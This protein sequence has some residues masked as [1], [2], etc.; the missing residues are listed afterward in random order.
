MRNQTSNTMIVSK[1]YCYLLIAVGFLLFS[2]R[3]FA[4][5]NKKS[6]IKQDEKEGLHS[7]G[8][9][10]GFHTADNTEN[11]SIS[12][13]LIGDSI[14]HGYRG[15]VSDS[16]KNFAKVD[17]WVTG[18]HL[19]SESLLED[20]KDKI[21]RRNYAVIHFNIG[22]HGWQKERIPEGQYVPLLKRYILTIKQYA[23][24]A[25]L[26]WANTTPVT[27]QGKPILNKDINPIIVER[28]ALAANVMKEHGVVINDLYGLMVD[29]LDLARL[30][31]FHWIGAGYKLMSDQIITH[32]KA[33][34]EIGN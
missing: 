2:P 19:N 21:T 11:D 33:E 13:L 3:I 4:Q 27:E 18:M 16:L 28:N 7:D 14:L 12:I 29:K 9:A 26:I 24:N 31:R 20:L 15:N 34:I 30:D 5:T 17:S 10:W 22:L 23:P 1:I 6:D 8:G 25:K 32:I